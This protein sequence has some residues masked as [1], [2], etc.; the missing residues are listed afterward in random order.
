MTS[1][2]FH[3]LAQLIMKIIAAMT[4]QLVQ[5]AESCTV[6][7]QPTLSLCSQKSQGSTGVLQETTGEKKEKRVSFDFSVAAN[8][9]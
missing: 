4:A 9:L 8:I 1:Y 2:E 3:T 6:L 7:P 5:K